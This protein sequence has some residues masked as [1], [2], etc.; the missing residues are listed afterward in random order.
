MAEMISVKNKKCKCGYSQHIYGKK[1]I[2][3]YANKKWRIE[4]PMCNNGTAWCKTIE[5]AETI[6]G[7]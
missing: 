5:K 7:R 4:C 2:L 6:F 1:P 3:R